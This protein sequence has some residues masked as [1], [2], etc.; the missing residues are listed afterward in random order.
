M[1]GYILRQTEHAYVAKGQLVGNI[2]TPF[3]AA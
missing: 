2:G 1:P 3:A